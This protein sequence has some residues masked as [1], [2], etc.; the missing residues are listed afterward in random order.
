MI[1]IKIYQEKYNIYKF[2][3]NPFNKKF[4]PCNGLHSFSLQGRI[5]K[6]YIRG[7]IINNELFL[8]AFY[9]YNQDD[10]QDF[11]LQ[12]LYFKSEKILKLYLKELLK[13]IEKNF[14]IIPKKIIFN[15][16]KDIL[17]NGGV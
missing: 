12:E 11:S 15:A 17:K 13:E 8:R 2:S 1:K 5:F 14:K 6:D 4:I 9:P 16:D 3:Y 10:I 7:V